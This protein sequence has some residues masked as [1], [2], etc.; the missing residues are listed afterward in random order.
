M[1]LRLTMCRAGRIAGSL[2]ARKQGN[3]VLTNEQ[4]EDL[5]HGLLVF[6]APRAPLVF[7]PD[8]L[9]RMLWR[10]GL[11]DFEPNVSDVSAA[12]DVLKEL[13]FAA[14]TKDRLG[15][16]VYYKASAAGVLAWERGEV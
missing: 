8:A 13:G 7:A 14:E 10:K 16:S 4:K 3:A 2:K 11:V 9:C 6:L 1:T 12:L 15:A 5:R